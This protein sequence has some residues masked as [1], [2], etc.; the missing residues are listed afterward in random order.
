MIFRE[1]NLFG[2]RF[3]DIYLDIVHDHF[4]FTLGNEP[5]VV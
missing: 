1:S 5:Y 3:I 4:F 2:L